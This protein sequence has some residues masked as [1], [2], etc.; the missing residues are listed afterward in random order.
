MAVPGSVRAAAVA[1]AMFTSSFTL[2]ASA[3]QGAGSPKIA[4][5]D[6]ERIVTESATG[7]AALAKLEAYGKEQ[8]GRLQ[9]KKDEIEALR[10]KISD[11]QL[12]LAEDK[13]N[14]MRKDLE[15]KGIELRRATDDAQREFNTRQQTALG[16]IE[17][18]VMPVIK[19]MGEEGGYSM[20]FR[21]FD[22]GLVFATDEID[23]TQQVIQRL[24]ASQPAENKPPGKP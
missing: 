6:V 8:E 16:D 3:Q 23:I 14:D 20:I 10:K 13:L 17:R 11:G 7:K 5:I 19:K 4:I 9:A 1:V 21:K 15:N 22:S 18:K 2:A 12:S 24:D